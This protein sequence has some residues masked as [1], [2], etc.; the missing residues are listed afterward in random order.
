MPYKFETN[1][2]RKQKE[3]DNR[4]KLTDE[5]KEEI[6]RL[7]ATGNYSQSELGRMFNVHRRTIDFI[8][9]PEKMIENN[10]KRKERGKDG[11]YYDKEKH[12]EYMRE[13]RRRKKALYEQGRLFQKE[14]E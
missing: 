4:I 8:I 1:H 10:N 2:F 9:D 3:D 12:R 14:E 13:Y 7:Y 6:K 11:R 5:D